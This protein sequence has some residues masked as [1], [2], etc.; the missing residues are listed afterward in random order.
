MDVC[1]LS[2]ASAGLD[3]TSSSELVESVDD[4]EVS[5]RVLDCVVD[6]CGRD[7]FVIDAT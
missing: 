1:G 4:S 3:D 5:V 6:E 7:V 2:V